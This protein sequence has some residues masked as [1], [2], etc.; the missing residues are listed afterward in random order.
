MTLETLYRSVYPQDTGL[1]DAARE[2]FADVQLFALLL[3]RLQKTPLK[4]VLT[5]SPSGSG[6]DRLMGAF[7]LLLRT[8]TDCRTVVM[9]TRLL[10]HVCTSDFDP[11]VVTQLDQL[12]T[13]YFDL[14][15]EDVC[16]EFIPT[17]RHGEYF[18]TQLQQWRN[19]V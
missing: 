6:N 4:L 8:E 17:A 16:Y 9:F 18:T 11:A 1:A 5:V 19:A 13:Q 15:I 12:L 7:G 2:L 14:T 3:P 10:Q